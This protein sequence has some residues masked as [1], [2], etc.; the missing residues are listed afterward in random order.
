MPDKAKLD[1][2][3]WLNKTK[4]EM[5]WFHK[6]TSQW[7]PLFSNKFQIVDQ[8]TNVYP[9]ESPVLGQL[10]LNNGLLMYWD[11]SNW[12]PVKTLQEDNSQFDLSVFENHVLISPFY[13]KDYDPTSD[14]DRMWNLAEQGKSLCTESE[15]GGNKTKWTFDK[16]FCSSCGTGFDLTQY[17]QYLVPSVK[18]TR[19]FIDGELRH[20]FKTISQVCLAYPKEKLL[21]HRTSAIHLNAGRLRKLTKKIMKIDKTNA[22]IYFDDKDFEL[23]GFQ[24]NNPLGDLLFPE[25]EPDD[26]GYIKTEFG[27]ILSYNQ[28]QNY[29]YVLIA[30]FDFGY[31]KTTGK[32]LYVNDQNEKTSFYLPNFLAPNNI[33]VQ[34]FNLEETAYTT[35][36]LDKT[37]TIPEDVRGLDVTGFHTVLREHG[38]VRDVDLNGNAI[39][40]TLRDYKHPLLFLNGQAITATDGMTRQNN[41][42]KVPGGAMNMVWAVAELAEESDPNFNMFVRNGI[43]TVPPSLQIP[44]DKNDVK[45]SDTLILFIDGLMVKIEDVIRDTKKGTVTV[46]GIHAGQTFLLL[47]DRYNRAYNESELMPALYVGSRFSES[48]VYLDNHLIN[49]S[50]S[51]NETNAIESVA[52]KHNQIKFFVDTENRQ[53]ITGRYHIYK[54][55]YDA[56]GNDISGWRYLDP[57]S[58][59]HI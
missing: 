22:K 32:Q 46:D 54:E 28:M 42:W 58:L 2:A 33:F 37:I 1:G 56:D 41:I 40:K 24:A 47:K 5:R 14:D 11:G 18:M 16:E 55:E 13:H 51:I 19:F 17:R 53:T 7:K 31:F 23:Y 4:N 59:I 12:Q 21:H 43:G 29:D 39:I 26:G 6:A 25:R 50:M 15:F 9:S 35:N 34:G 57:L 45:D 20:D 27:C 10:W 36:S 52:G 49:N 38:F 48:L 44:Y 30:S 3:L 8:I